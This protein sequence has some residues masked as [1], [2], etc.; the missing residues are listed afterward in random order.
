[1]LH[2]GK[3]RQGVLNGMQSWEVCESQILPR[4]DPCHLV[5]SGQLIGDLKV[6]TTRNGT[7]KARSKGPHC[8][9]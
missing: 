3:V 7:A 5:M 8:R 9:D 4:K 2:R 1:M 6:P